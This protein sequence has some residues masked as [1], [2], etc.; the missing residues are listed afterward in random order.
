MEAADFTLRQPG[1]RLG[2]M[3]LADRISA[4]GYLTVRATPN[5]KRPRIECDGEAVRVWVSAPP[6]KGR[7]NRAVA[8]AVAAAVGIPAGCV[9]VV[10]GQTARV[11]V[12]QISGLR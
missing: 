10:R 3:E 9:S 5:A 4:D 8:A 1:T 7:A 6:E 12:L 2:A 11:K